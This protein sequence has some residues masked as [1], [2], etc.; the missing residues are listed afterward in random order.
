VVR[1]SSQGIPLDVDTGCRNISVSCGAL[2]TTFGLLVPLLLGSIAFWYRFSIV[3]RPYLRKAWKEPREV[4]HTADKGVG[5]VVGRD[6]LCHIMVEDL[7]Y[8]ETPRPKLIVGGAG[9]GKTE[10]LVQLTKLLAQLGAVPVF[11]W[12]GDAQEPIDFRKLARQQFLTDAALTDD[13]EGE[14]IWRHLCDREQIV[15]LADSLEDALVGGK[16]KKDGDTL[17]RVAIQQVNDSGLPLIIA[18]RPHDQLRG[19]GAAIIDLEPLSEEAALQYVQGRDQ[20]GDEDRL[21][22]IVQTADLADTPQ[23]LE[24]TRSLRRVGLLEYVSSSP[25]SG[26]LD[27]SGV[28]RAELRLSLLETWMQALVRGQLPPGVRMSRRDRQAVVEQLS[29][30]ACIGLKRDQAFVS[31]DDLASPQAE[32]GTATVG[33]AVSRARR[34]LSRVG[35]SFALLGSRRMPGPSHSAIK[36]EVERRLRIHGRRLDLR[37]AATWGAR[38]GLVEAY[39]DGVRFQSGIMQAYLGSRL[40]HVAMT[41]PQY[42]DEALHEA[43]RDFL[44]ALVMCSRAKVRQARQ[45]RP[46]RVRIAAAG[47]RDEEQPLQDLLCEAAS[48]HTDVKALDLFAAALEIDSGEKARAHGV[49]V[50][51]LE[52]R[53]QKLEARDQRALHEVKLGLVQRLGETARMIAEQRQEDPD[54]PVETGYRQLYRIIC[55]EPAYPIR[56]VAAQ[57]IGEGGDEAFDALTYTLGPHSPRDLPDGQTAAR[58]SRHTPHTFGTPVDEEECWWRERVLRAWLAPLLVGSVTKRE[59]D[60]RENFQQWLNFVME[61]HWTEDVGLSLEVALAQGLKHAANRR[62]AHPHAHAEVRAYLAEQTREMLRGARSWFSR[63]TLVHALCLW[64]LPDRTGSQRLSRGHDIDPRALVEHWVTIPGGGEPEHPFVIE[65]RKL[66]VWA[67]ETRQP[68]RF[69]WMDESSVV[70]RFGS[71]PDGPGS[72]RK[73]NLWIG[74]SIGWSALHPRAQQLVADV[75]LLL[76]L[77]ERGRRPS[78]RNRRL[79]RTNRKDLPPCLAGD[80]SPLDP[81]Q[82]FITAEIAQPGMTCTNGCPIELCPYPQKGQQPYWTELSDLFCARQQLLTN[83]GWGRGRAAPWQG[84]LRS[85]LLEFWDQMRQRARSVELDQERSAD[86]DQGGTD[87]ES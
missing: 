45:N 52:K 70:A 33:M 4:V 21:H 74:P 19:M 71:R 11:V 61:N 44:T 36:L 38:L 55:A 39:G 25:D 43:G 72:R 28:D 27:S 69:I 48:G 8:S 18:S 50:D 81:T 59:G 73:H 49:I 67:L 31:L 17:I 37:L 41:D 87:P 84:A 6:E 57:E 23:Y 10:L 34:A 30:L 1:G 2:A 79:Q 13:A 65:A 26:H 78:D 9:T 68:E 24:I 16:A 66:A 76:N 86:R 80:R 42:R 20:S 35:A 14:R 63:L 85:E 64:A 7:R 29:G 51:T 5:E 15:V 46:S 22:W 60:A 47:P 62:R 77:A 12:L 53:W 83:G 3:H 56:L 54:W 58:P 32:Q 75:L 40:I 82:T